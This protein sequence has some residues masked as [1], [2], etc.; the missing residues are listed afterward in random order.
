M[1]SVLLSVEIFMS[2]VPES[3]GKEEREGG[4]RRKMEKDEKLPKRVKT[5][6]KPRVGSIPH[7]HISCC[8]TKEIEAFLSSVTNWYEVNHQ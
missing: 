6:S 4:L 8:P 1:N 7:K 2:K 3:N 5:S